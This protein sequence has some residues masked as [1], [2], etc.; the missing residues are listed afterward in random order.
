M[1][2]KTRNL[3]F[4]LVMALGLGGV[5]ASQATAQTVKSMRGVD[6]GAPELPPGDYQRAPDI[7]VLR[8]FVQQPPMVPHKIDG[9]EIT[10]KFN[11]CMECH[12]WSN[13]LEEGAV[14]VSL[15]HFRDRDGGELSNIS[16]R[17]YFCLQCHV[18]QTDAAPLVE[19]VFRSPAGL[20]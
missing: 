5:A 11:E 10:M 18:P 4:A 7:Q 19:N 15:T 20:R 1:N 6:V 9:Y 2:R 8:N 16:P 13:Y 3:A 17:Q 14:K 12:S